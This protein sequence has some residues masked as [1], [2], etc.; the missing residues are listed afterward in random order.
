MVE[1][2]CLATSQKTTDCIYKPP[3]SLL[4]GLDSTTFITLDTHLEVSS[5]IGSDYCNFPAY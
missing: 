4:N 5:S 2:L 3:H 1:T